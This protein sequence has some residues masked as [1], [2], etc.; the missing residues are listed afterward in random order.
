[1]VYTNKNHSIFGG[2]TRNYLFRQC[3]NF[4]NENLK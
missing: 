2:N 4:M 3:I 1:L